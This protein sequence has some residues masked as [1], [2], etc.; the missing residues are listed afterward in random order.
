M[1]RDLAAIANT[2]LDMPGGGQVPLKDVAT[3]SAA[4]APAEIDHDQASRFLDVTADVAG[5]DVRGTVDRVRGAVKDLPLPVGYHV[6]VSSDVVVSKNADRSTL[7]Y[8]AFVVVGVFLLLQA[9]LRSWRRAA[10]LFCALPLALAGGVATAPIA[11]GP[12][13]VGAL[14]GFLAV[15]G[16]AVRAGLVVMRDLDGSPTASSAVFPTMVSAVGLVL[17]MLPFAVVG[18]IAG[19]EVVRPLALV[20]IGGMASTVLVMLVLLPAL[21]LRW[22]RS[23]ARP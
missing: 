20:V 15:F 12:L 11:G 21:H 22:N 19:L 10:L 13:T 4:S 23:A 2:P 8:A 3:V 16:V 18:D 14:V 17:V 6:E 7:I 5:G 1:R 9:A